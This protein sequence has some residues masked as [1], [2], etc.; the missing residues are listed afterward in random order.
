M[1]VERRI[2]A[3]HF[4]GQEAPRVMLDDG[5][6]LVGLTYLRVGNCQ[7]HGTLIDLG[8]RILDDPASQPLPD[9]ETRPC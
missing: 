9:K 2:V 6:E 1:K 8:A 4:Q 7:E 3:V 5:S